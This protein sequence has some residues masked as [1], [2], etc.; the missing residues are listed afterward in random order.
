MNKTL[1]KRSERA[2]S[3]F[4]H[5]L[6]P[7]RPLGQKGR[8][9]RKKLIESVKKGSMPTSWGK[10]KN[11]PVKGGRP[12]YLK[13]QDATRLPWTEKGKKNLVEPLQATFASRK[14]GS[15]LSTTSREG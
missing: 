4:R 11:P 12:A 3:S 8:H 1:M 5:S 6:R 15:Y 7:F 10:G 14:E 9:L 2:A 13:E